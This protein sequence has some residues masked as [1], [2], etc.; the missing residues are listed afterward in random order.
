MKI[1]NIRRKAGKKYEKP[2]WELYERAFPEAEKK[3]LWLFEKMEAEG[4]L[5]ILALEWEGRF[6]GLIINMISGDKALLDYFAIE[7][8]IR[9]AG[10]GSRA[11]REM[12]ARFR[13]RKYILEIEALNP[14][15]EN[16]EE[17]KRRKYFYLKNGVKETGV[18]AYVYGTDFELLSSDGVLT[19]EEYAVFLENMM[20]DQVILAGKMY[21]MEDPQKKDR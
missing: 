5:E 11:I 18:F 12:L 16:Y 6:A 15:A 4:R 9:G 13:D 7:D 19:Y 21:P 8:S 2:L 17:R 10:L 14:Q 3:P 20:K 1:I